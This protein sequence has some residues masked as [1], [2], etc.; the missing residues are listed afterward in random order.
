MGG[1]E[2]NFQATEVNC[3]M[4]DSSK[5]QDDKVGNLDIDMNT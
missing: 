3:G 4:Y 2:Y 1:S 5:I